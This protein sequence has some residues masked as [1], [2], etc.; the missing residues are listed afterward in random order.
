MGRLRV[1]VVEANECECRI[2]FAEDCADR[3]AFEIGVFCT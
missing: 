3:R 2:E 1:T